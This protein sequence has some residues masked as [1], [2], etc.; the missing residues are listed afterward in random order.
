MFFA[1]SNP[2]RVCE[3]PTKGK[4]LGCT[5]PKWEVVRWK[6][7]LE[8]NPDPIERAQVTFTS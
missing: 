4:A 8:A 6:K 2:I 7:F 3:D 1:E 5:W